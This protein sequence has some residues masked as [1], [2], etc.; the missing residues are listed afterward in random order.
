MAYNK[1]PLRYPG[2]KSK[3]LTKLWEQLPNL[4]AYDE[5]REP[6]LGGGS[7]AIHISRM[8]PDLQ[9]W[10]NDLYEPLY[11]FW[12]V[13]QRNVDDLK[14]ELLELKE[15]HS[16]SEGYTDSN[17]FYE[18]KEYLEKPLTDTT[19]MGRAVAFY[20]TNKCSFSGL[21]MNSS[22]SR[23]ASKQ[24]FKED[25]I[26]YLPKFSELIQN[27]EI[28]NLSYER[29]LFDNLSQINTKKFLYLDPPYEIKSNLYGT[30]G[31][32]HKGFSHELFAKD[33]AKCDIDQL[34]SY[35][36]SVLDEDRFK[37]WTA[38]TYDHTYSLRHSDK[39][40]I[41]NQKQRKELLLRNYVIR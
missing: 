29:L 31:D 2:G 23:L 34:I 8:Y 17:L 20:V 4:N 15:E 38:S 36:E 21:S 22:Y 7:V 26:K 13:L 14:S 10:V 30:R 1:T 35:N 19:P 27:W 9:V 18:K 12:R 16:D 6:F 40:Y 39:K 11:Q 3:A 5:Y 24:N 28:T 33:C 41:E 37:G 32:M 25:G